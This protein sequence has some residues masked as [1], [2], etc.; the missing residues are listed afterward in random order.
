MKPLTL[1]L[2]TLCACLGAGVGG[3]FYGK[4]LGERL[5]A[6]ARDASAVGQL[7]TLI[8]AQK[9]LVA[10]ANLAS[11]A[12]RQ[13]TSARLLADQQSTLELQDALRA[14]ADSRA[15]CVFDPGVLRQL[16]AARDRAAQAAASGLRAAVPAPGA[17][18]AK[19]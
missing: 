17:S 9:G 4:H 16:T 12:M 10:Q 3:F 18:A 14:T 6:G 1:A 2:L 15:G 19:P 11:R 7:T 13:A 5:E 8:E